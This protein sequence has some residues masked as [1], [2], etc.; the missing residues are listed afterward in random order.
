L[1]K[2]IFYNIENTVTMAV[3]RQE[4]THTNNLICG[5]IDCYS[6][7]HIDYKPNIPFEL[8]GLLGGSCETCNHSL[9][10]HHSYRAKWEQV[11]DTQ[12]SIDQDMKKRWEAAKDSKEQRVVLTEAGQKVESD[13]DLVINRATDELG[14]QVERYARLSLSGSFSAQVDSAIR[15]LEQNYMALDKKGV[16]RDQLQ[17]VTTS[18]DRMRGKRE[19]LN[20]AK[21]KTQDGVRTAS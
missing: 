6:N 2:N 17:K 16:G 11:I 3:W 1:D 7:C 10:N 15:L 8:R 20:N 19:L 21:G 5:E 12:V 4:P 9:W 13:F 18:L 14:Q